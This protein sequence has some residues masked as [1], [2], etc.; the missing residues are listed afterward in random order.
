MDTHTLPADHEEEV[1]GIKTLRYNGKV[2]AKHK[3]SK[4]IDESTSG[5]IK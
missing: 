2:G 5:S 4:C 3:G 1:V